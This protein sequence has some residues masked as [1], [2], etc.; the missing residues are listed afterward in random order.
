MYDKLLQRIESKQ[1]QVVIIFFTLFFVL[2]IAG[3]KDYGLSWD[4]GIQWKANGEVAATYAAHPNAETRQVLLNSLEKYHGPAFEIVLIFFEK[5]FQLEDSRAVYLMRHAIT[6]LT[7]FTAVIFFYFL[8]KRIFK[9]WKLALTGCIFLVLSPRIFADSF[10][11]SKDIPFLSFFLVSMYALLLFHEQPSYKNALVYAIVSAFTIDIRIVGIILPLI[12]LVF[13]STDLLRAFLYKQ[14]HTTY[15]KIFILYSVSLILFTILFWPVLWNSPVYYFSKA[16]EEMSQY[17]WPGTILYKGTFMKATTHPWH[18]LPVWIGIT[19]P[20]PYLFL[21]FAGLFFMLQEYWKKPLSF[22]FYRKDLQLMAACSVV[23]IL[24]IILLKSTVY[25]GWRHVYFIYPAFTLIVLYGLRSIYTLLKK[26]KS[27]VISGLV[28]IILFNLLQLFRLHPHEYVYFNRLAGKDMAAVKEKFDLDYYGVS[29]KE[30]LEYILKNDSSSSIKIFPEL[31]PQRLNIQFL[32]VS[33]RNRVK[34]VSLKDADYFIG[35]YRFHKG[36][37][38][39]KNKCFSVMIGNA[40][41]MSV[42]KLTEEERTNN[43][44]HI[45]TGIQNN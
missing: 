37:Y 33:Q 41:I 6:F 12:S 14:R 27:F 18:Y 20:L 4:E 29:S 13:F 42:F 5:V 44:L 24:I 30:V 7:F 1:K 16:W 22:I 31:I 45:S 40:S 25:D 8:G 36:E 38:T 3:L 26:Y 10:Y 28:F 19:T 32:P 9:S 11:N 17:T 15:L 21:F 39:F 34:L 23:T 43:S 2:S 35:Q